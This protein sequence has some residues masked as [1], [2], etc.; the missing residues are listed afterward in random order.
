M[1]SKQETCLINDRR[2]IFAGMTIAKNVFL[3]KNKL[4]VS[5]D[6]NNFF[7]FHFQPRQRKRWNIKY[8]GK[9]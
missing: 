6:L 1:K 4:F 5:A 9:K 2:N 8:E 3:K 7:F